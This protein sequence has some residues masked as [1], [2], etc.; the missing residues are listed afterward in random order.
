MEWMNRNIRGIANFIE[1]PRAEVPLSNFSAHLQL[2][3]SML[4]I[5]AGDRID[6]YVSPSKLAIAY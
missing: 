5:V 2:L 4:S 3:L 6:R 1:F